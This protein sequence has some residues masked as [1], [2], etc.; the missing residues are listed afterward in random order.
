MSFN[1]KQQPSFNIRDLLKQINILKTQIKNLESN[2]IDYQKQIENLL[3]SLDNE[4]QENIKRNDRDVK[5]RSIISKFKVKVVNLNQE[6]KNLKKINNNYKTF[7]GFLDKKLIPEVEGSQSYSKYKN[8]C[9]RASA[10]FNEKFFPYTSS[11]NNL[12][13]DAVALENCIIA[14]KLHSLKFHNLNKTSNNTSTSVFD[15]YAGHTKHEM[16]LQK[17]LLDRLQAI[18]DKIESMKQKQRRL[19]RT[20][21]TNWRS[22]SS[23]GI[24]P[25]PVSRKGSFRGGSSPEN[26][27]D[28]KFEKWLKNKNISP[29]TGKKLKKT[30]ATYK[31][32]EKEFS[33]YY[34][35][36]ILVNIATF[37]KLKKHLEKLQKFMGKTNLKKLLNYENLLLD[38]LPKPHTHRKANLKTLLK[39]LKL[40][41]QH[42]LNIKKILKI[43][44]MDLMIEDRLLPPINRMSK[45]FKKHAIKIIQYL[46]TFGLNL[47]YI[48]L[49]IDEKVL[50]SMRQKQACQAI[51][52]G[53]KN[54]TGIDIN[55]AD[56]IKLYM[57]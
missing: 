10:I 13:D 6:I 3:Q 9:S 25:P 26:A 15:S 23:S 43:K 29:K 39:R 5:V 48:L 4:I 57:G 27:H 41:E 35:K 19:D 51:K 32:L 31:K 24:R 34:Y 36:T 14:R 21:S 53:L 55:I 52:E 17:K 56:I 8:L 18:G 42:G 40:L 54:K 37:G 1:P 47:Q 38:I 22:S 33:D 45:E 49:P 46:E 50:A 16:T 28:L 30:S 12:I 20:Q 2:R 7:F 44:D 11:I